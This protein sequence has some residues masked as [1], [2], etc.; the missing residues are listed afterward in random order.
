MAIEP[1]VFI[2]TSFYTR[3]SIFSKH[4]VSDYKNQ[5]SRAGLL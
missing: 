5:L 4:A 1:A 2:L 3:V